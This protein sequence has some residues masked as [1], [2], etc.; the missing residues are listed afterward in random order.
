MV[1][2]CSF[3]IWPPGNTLQKKFKG[4]QQEVSVRYI[5]VNPPGSS[6]SLP[7][8]R[9]DSRTP[10]SETEPPGCE[11]TKK[12]NFFFFFFSRPSFLRI[13]MVRSFVAGRQLTAR[14]VW[15]YKP[16][17]SDTWHSNITLRRQLRASQMICNE[18]LLFCIYF[19]K[20]I[21]TF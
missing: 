21:T 10:G 5:H 15:I 20:S 12:K 18:S 1:V 4:L 8:M 7:E 19:Y 13:C 11:N 17:Q 6:G 16:W 2:Q 9:P 3:E 14:L